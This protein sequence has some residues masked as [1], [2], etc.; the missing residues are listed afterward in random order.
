MR[1]KLPSTLTYE[2][3]VGKLF[4]TP[5][6]HCKWSYA[7]Y[8]AFGWKFT[9][10]LPSLRAKILGPP[11][12]PLSL[13]CK[14]RKFSPDFDSIPKATTTPYSVILNAHAKKL[15]LVALCKFL[16]ISESVDISIQLLYITNRLQLQYFTPV[17]GLK[18]S[19]YGHSARKY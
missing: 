7:I 11:P 6:S 15:M 1:E 19:L 16:F 9:Y 13:H 5:R 4:K 3:G 2:Y 18:I 14:D 8:L 12:S 17:G 10:K